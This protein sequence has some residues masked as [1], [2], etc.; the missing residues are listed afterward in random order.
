MS[1]TEVTA[2]NLSEQAIVPVA[3]MAS[4]YNA[5]GEFLTFRLGAEEYG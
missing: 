3:K 5:A 4:Q 1:T 2:V